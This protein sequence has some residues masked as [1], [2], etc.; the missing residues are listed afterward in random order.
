MD[1]E[2]LSFVT[3]AYSDIVIGASSDT[4]VEASSHTVVVVA[5]YTIAMADS[6]TT[7]GTFYPDHCSTRAFAKDIAAC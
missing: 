4:I 3:E 6:S 1:T 5:F 7:V 2:V